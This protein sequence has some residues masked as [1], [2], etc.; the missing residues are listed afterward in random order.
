MRIY[1]LVQDSIVDGPG[2]RFTC[3]V[4][5]CPHHCPGCHNPDS[6]DFDGG[7][8]MTTDEV[9]RKML[10]NPLTDGLTL[11][12]GEPFSQAEDCLTIAKA[13]HAHGLNVWSYSG[14]TFDHLLR[15]G[16]DVQ[17]ALL[18]EIDVLVDG[19]FILDQRS[20]SLAWRGSGNQR[21]IDVQASLSAE[22]VILRE[23]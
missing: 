7:T 13:A 8:E 5:G 22:K 9:I 16:S 14:W 12:G 11:S 19:P 3:F 2:F 6:H 21:V 23:E 1:G 17:K 18:R 15:D 10:S 20:L 4:Q